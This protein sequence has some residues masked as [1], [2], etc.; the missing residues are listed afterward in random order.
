MDSVNCF[1]PTHWRTNSNGGGNGFWVFNGYYFVTVIFNCLSYW[2]R[3][4]GLDACH[5]GQLFD[6]AKFVEFSKAL[7]NSAYVPR[8]ADGYD[9][10]VWGFVVELFADFVAQ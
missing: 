10:A 8:V 9:N 1:L 4:C 6:V 5:L 2:R 7:P 3:T